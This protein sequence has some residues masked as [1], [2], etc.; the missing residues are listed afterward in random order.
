[1]EVVATF[2]MSAPRTM[3]SDSDDDDDD[4]P[5]M[6]YKARWASA[7]PKASSSGSAGGAGDTKPAIPQPTGGAAPAPRLPQRNTDSHSDYEHLRRR[8]PILPFSRTPKTSCC[9]NCWY[10]ARPLHKKRNAAPLR[11]AH[12]TS[13][14]PYCGFDVYTWQPLRWRDPPSLDPLLRLAGRSRAV[15]VGSYDLL[16]TPRRGFLP[17]LSGELVVA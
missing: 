5:L 16:D 7:T 1:M 13:P 8:C 14:R 10:G 11:C 6:N 12:V 17:R 9:A 2:T 15:F 4:L 3:G